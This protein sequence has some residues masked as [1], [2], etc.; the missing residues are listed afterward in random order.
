[1]KT[2]G[3]IFLV[4]AVVAFIIGFGMDTSVSSGF[5]KRVHNI[6]LLNDRQNIIILAGAMAIVG[7]I[8][9][10]FS[11]KQK[12]AKGQFSST[13]TCPFCAETIRA[14]AI[15]CRYCKK[16]LPTTPQFEKMNSEPIYTTE[17]EELFEATRAG[18]LD[19]VKELIESGANPNA[20]DSSGYTP[21]DYARGHG[22]HEIQK[23]L[24]NNQ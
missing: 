8:F 1:M 3:I 23:F 14:Q 15:I 16:E 4:V 13:R 10:A 19:R 18:N 7:A 22:F 5:D 12:P 17:S 6:G 2:L 20:K 11:N 9:V 24:K 21:V